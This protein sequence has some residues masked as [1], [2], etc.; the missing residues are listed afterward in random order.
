MTFAELLEQRWQFSTLSELEQAD[1]LAAVSD[2]YLKEFRHLLTDQQIILFEGMLK[3][4]K[5]FI[6]EEEDA[7]AGAILEDAIKRCTS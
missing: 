6:H 4:S 7:K 1:V 3:A 5:V 2:V